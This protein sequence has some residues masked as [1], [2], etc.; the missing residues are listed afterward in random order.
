MLTIGKHINA[1]INI[2]WHLIYI[3]DAMSARDLCLL[4]H[5]Q[6]KKPRPWKHE[7]T[8]TKKIKRTAST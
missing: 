3:I 2:Q 1:N 4:M 6:A 5:L 7:R 8:V